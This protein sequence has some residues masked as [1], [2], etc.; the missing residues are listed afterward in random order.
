MCVC[1]CGMCNKQ[2]GTHDS[3]TLLPARVRATVP[4]TPPTTRSLD[5]MCCCCCCSLLLLLLLLRA[6]AHQLLDT[7]KDATPELM[8]QWEVRDSKHVPKDLRPAA[9]QIRCACLPAEQQQGARC[10]GR[11]QLHC[12]SA[13]ARRGVAASSSAQRAAAALRLS[14]SS[15]L[16]AGPCCSGRPVGRRKRA[17]RAQERLA[18]VA[19]AT[20]L[21]EAHSEGKA[22]AKLCKALAA[23]DKAKVSNW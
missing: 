8:W 15:T 9:L 18:A 22:S 3:R 16:I 13:A 19:A 5:P 1:V 2:H 21:L 23:L 11:Q 7:L 20:R 12:A 17:T 6:A 4:P 10:G 14:R